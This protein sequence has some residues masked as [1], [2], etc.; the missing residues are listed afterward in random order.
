MTTT[1]ND[2][3]HRRAAA[4]LDAAREARAQNELFA[5]IIESLPDGLVLVDADGKIAFINREAEL[6]FGYSRHELLGQPHST[7][8][9]ETQRLVHDEHR[10]AYQRSP[11]I[12]S[13]GF[14]GLSLLGRHKGG[15]SFPVDIM[16]APIIVDAGI[17][18]VAV[19]RRN[20]P[21]RTPI[22]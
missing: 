14:P 6:L 5:Q 7:L 21:P 3:D 22:A 1:T 19:V 17:F 20:R 11:H 10:E 4:R 18:T 12:R 16:L 8:I 2:D 15:H 9:P 13:M